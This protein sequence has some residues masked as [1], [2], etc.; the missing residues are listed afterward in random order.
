M[1]KICVVTAARSEY[2]LLKW[3]MK[4]IDSANDFELQIIATGAHLLEEQGRTVDQIKADGFTINEEVDTDLVTESKEEIAASMG[5]MAEGMARAFNRLKPDYVVVLGDRYELLPICN[6]AFV[7]N[8]PIIHISG[9]DVT[10]GAIDDGIRNAVTM[11]AEYHFPGTGESKNNIV[12]MRGTDRNVWTV[13]EPGLDSF[14][15]EKLMTKEEVAQSVGLN[16]D[17]PWVLF[18]FHPE[19]KDSFDYNIAAVKNCI[20]LLLERD[21]QIVATY[22]NADIGGKEINELLEKIALD[23][24]EKMVVIP[25]LGHQRFISFMNYVDLVVGNSSSGIVEAPTLGVPV[26]NVG[27]RQKGRHLCA[28]VIQTNAQADSIKDAIDR[29]MTSDFSK[30]DDYWGDGHTAEKIISIMKKEL[31]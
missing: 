9:G 17:K 22:A 31:L 6:T 1:K 18:T 10:E 23:N 30:K 13:G 12:R 24:R 27:D 7:M 14:Y 11:L 19:T 16:I 28:N 21:V 8:I 15:R 5:R 4:E 26:V 20:E 3:L 2:G 29:A 25:S